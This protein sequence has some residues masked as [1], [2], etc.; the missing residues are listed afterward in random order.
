VSNHQEHADSAARQPFSLAVLEIQQ[1]ATAVVVADVCVK[2]AD[3]QL[4]DIECNGKGGLAI[5]LVG[6]TADVED[7]LA[8]G[9]RAAES[10]HADF[11]ITLL[12]RYPPDARGLVYCKQEY[13][14]ITEG[15]DH[16]LP[17]EADS[18]ASS[19]RPE[20]DKSFAVGLIETQGLVG[21][22]EATDAMLKA[23]SVELLGKEKIG[24]AYVTVM[25]KG[26]VSAVRAAV[27]AGVAAVE[28][29]GQKLICAHV[30]PKPHD[31]LVPLL[32]VMAK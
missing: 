15:Y 28:K 13:N 25:V 5:K 1:L 4:V 8:A 14:A 24:A 12:R 31:A 11:A 7:G 18:A 29:L 3:V 16:L 26:D 20:M 22:L 6:P 27:Q 10:M 23:A 32:P 9:R 21:V 2:A 30:I 19:P 17:R